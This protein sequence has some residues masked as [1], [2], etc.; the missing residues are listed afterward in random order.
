MAMP[1]HERERGIIRAVRVSE[2][3]WA[4]GI[5]ALAAALGLLLRSHLQTIDV[6][7]IFL[8]AVVVVGYQY[9]RGPALV[10]ALLS[11]GAFDF[12][13]VPPYYTFDV[14][15]QAYYLTFAV[16]LVVAL[17]MGQLT[18]RIREQAQ[19]AGER[20][21]RARALYALSRDL[22][23]GGDLQDQFGMV[24]R[25]ISEAGRGDAQVFL[26]GSAHELRPGDRPGEGVFESVDVRVAATWARENGE[27]AG[28]GTSHCAAAEAMVVP[29][30]SP[31]RIVG[32]VTVQPRSFDE[33][34][35]EAERKTVEVLA[36]EAAAAFERTI[37]FQAHEQARVEV[38]SERLRTALL[39]SLSHDLRTP[40][41]GI[42]G[43]A[44]S[45]LQDSSGL[46][47]EAQREM[48]ETILEESRRMTRLVTNLLDM[49]R[50]EAGAVVVQREWQPLEEALGVALLRVEERLVG[51]AVE[52]CLPPDL[53]LVP[54]DELL[55]EQVFI[56]LLENAARHTPPGTSIT[57]SAWTEREAVIV[58][59]RDSGPG[60]PLGEEETVFR[61]FH[62]TV[63]ADRTGPPGGSGLGL[64][65][66]RGL[67]TAHGGRLWVEQGTGGACFRF[68]LPLQGP[69][70][71]ILP[72]EAVEG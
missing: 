45:L 57:V 24:A 34:L 37:L 40:L 21:C 58:E 64:T 68:T 17:S 52:T 71:R 39:S 69:P 38:E 35:S 7:M 8:L 60:I 32:V 46:P 11:I 12:A 29:L 6:A 22:S 30:K 44:S 41:A 19:D 20:E 59:V 15:D 70:I 63:G 50:V 47:P 42:E 66:C 53:P 1:E 48:A 16:M 13:F 28:W 31:S 23:A 2:Y 9:R 4:V 54:I 56:N 33:V 55:V 62:R 27:T 18:A 72:A 3:V 65:I 26:D 51:H 14:H 36:H 10:A 61:R 49:V 5:I 25:H 67:I 43:A